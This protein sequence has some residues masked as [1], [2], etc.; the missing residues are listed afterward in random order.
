[1]QVVSDKVQSGHMFFRKAYRRARSGVDCAKKL[2]YITKHGTM[3]AY[4][5]LA[6][7]DL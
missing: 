5:A 1:M 2:D 3:F 6:N 4:K 7:F